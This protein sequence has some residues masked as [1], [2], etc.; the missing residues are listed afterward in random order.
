VKVSREQL[1]H[2]ATLARL[3][4]EP[5]EEEELARDLGSILAYVEKLSELDTSSVEP[6]AQV[7]GGSGES[8]RDDKVTN[9]P[10]TEAILSN[11]PERHGDQFKVPKI[12][13]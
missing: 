2:V 4:L 6:T 11:A 7:M 3:K 5:E 12:I 10:N 1:L 8:W 13:S 9:R